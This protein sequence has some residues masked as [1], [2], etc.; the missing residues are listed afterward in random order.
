MNVRLMTIVAFISAS[1]SIYSQKLEKLDDLTIQDF[2]V[3]NMGTPTIL[4]YKGLITFPYDQNPNNV[5][6]KDE[7]FSVRIEAIVRIL[8]KDHDSSQIFTG[9]SKTFE[10]GIRFRSINYY[11]RKGNSINTRKVDKRDL[12]VTSDSLA[13]S[14]D[15]SQIIQDSTAIIEFS[16]Y[17]ESDSKQN[18]DIFLDTEYLSKYYELNVYIPEI[19]FYELTT[20]DPSIK[21]QIEK[22]LPGALIG[23]TGGSPTGQLTPRILADLFGYANNKSR[24]VFCSNNL[25]SFR[26]DSPWNKSLTTQKKRIIN[27]KLNSSFEINNY[28]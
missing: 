28:R 15:Y 21:T 2:T 27:L 24:Q 9:I 3:L 19:Y 8:V 1:T 12:L 6:A 23:Y 7:Y 16:F 10:Q 20:S 4:S 18:I 25:I 17:S 14:I 5:G 22:G 13:Y 11:Y 26:I